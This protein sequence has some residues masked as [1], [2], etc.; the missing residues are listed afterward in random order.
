MKCQELPNDHMLLVPMK[1][2]G[3]I[4]GKEGEEI[5]YAD[6]L[7]NFSLLK[8]T[9]LGEQMQSVPLSQGKPLEEG[10]HLHWILPDSFTHGVRNAETN[11]AAYPC[12]PDRW[13]VTRMVTR[14]ENEMETFVSTK[15]FLVESNALLKNIRSENKHSSTFPI[16]QQDDLD[17]AYLGRSGEL[18]EMPEVQEYLQELTAIGYGE[19]TFCAYY[20][21]CRNV[22]GFYDALEGVEKGQITYQ[23]SGWYSNPSKDPLYG[24]QSEEEFQKK[25]K[26]LYWKVA[27]NTKESGILK[28]ENADN[29]E[30][31]MK[32]L[33]HGTI[34]GMNWEGKKAAYDTGIPKEN[35]KVAIGNSS[36]EAFAALLTSQKD[37]E[38]TDERIA[39]IF[40]GNQMESWLK[41]DGILES[42]EKLHEDTFDTLYSEE[43]WMLKRKPE[44][45][46]E[47]EVWDLSWESACALDKMNKKQKLLL[48][49]EAELLEK[50]KNLY[51]LWYKYTADKRK[52]Q[53][54]EAFKKE[55]L[56]QM[57]LEAKGIQKVLEERRALKKE[58]LQ[59][60]ETILKL[61]LYEKNT[62]KQIGTI[63]NK[64][65]LI[66]CAAERYFMP[67]EPVL[68]LAGAGMEN[69]YKKSRDMGV[70]QDGK[71]I[72]RMPGQLIRQFF[73]KIDCC[74]IEETIS[75]A[76]LDEYIAKKHLLP[77]IVKELILETM[78]LS[79]D[80]AGILAHRI[81]EKQG[82]PVMDSMFEQVKEAIIQMQ[83]GPYQALLF[84]ENVQS[85]AKELKFQGV[86][87][88]KAAFQYYVPPW[89]PLYMEWGIDYT[90]DGDSMDGEKGELNKW[91][92][93]D[94][95]YQ[96]T[97]ELGYYRKTGRYKGRM[98][99]TPHFMDRLSE[100]IKKYSDQLREQNLP[101]GKELS[102]LQMKSEDIDMMSQRLNGFHEYFLMERIS[103]QL[104]IS[105]LWL[106]D[107]EIK[108]V[109]SGFSDNQKE[110]CFENIENHVPANPY[111]DG[112]FSPIRAG[113]GVMTKL[114]LIDTF[115]RS[116]SICDE[117]N[118]EL[119][120]R[121]MACSEHFRD[122]K[123]DDKRIIF[124]PRLMQ[125]AKISA[126][127]LSA[128]D[129]EIVTNEAFCTS[130]IIGWF[131]PDYMDGSLMVLSEDGRPLGNFM[132]VVDRQRI[133]DVIWVN[134]PGDRERVTDKRHELPKEAKG[135]LLKCLKEF[136]AAMKE[137]V[138]KDS[139]VLYDFVNYLC[140]EICGMN[141]PG[142]AWKKD[143]LHF[144][145][146]PLALV[147]IGFRL[148]TCHRMS[149]P[150]TWEISPDF[151]EENSPW[152]VKFPLRLGEERKQGDGLAGFFKQGEKTYHRFYT[153]DYDR[154]KKD[155]FMVQNNQIALSCLETM[156]QNRYTLL[157]DPTLPFHVVSGILPIK[158]VQL[159][160]ELVSAALGKLN[161]E[162]PV[163]PILTESG[164]IQVP[165]MQMPERT[166]SWI[167]V[168]DGNYVEEE[169]T[170]QPSE[171][172]F[173]AAY[174]IRLAEGW[175]KL[176]G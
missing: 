89:N 8:H 21:G 159:S 164:Q 91:Q 14:E 119:Q 98:L 134:V 167:W 121:A 129:K 165:F 65:E 2:E 17:Y 4:V 155:G 166:W 28:E 7:V 51:G 61:P 25:L 24:I 158:K 95:D 6:T 156:E 139:M 106:K 118:Y 74:E 113:Y 34:C 83:K 52:E 19:P 57:K 22:F 43:K 67:A 157:M 84:G 107:K 174:P 85:W 138:K 66:T 126:S 40:F 36:G 92:L 63:Q 163:Y 1:V 128:K 48:E 141:K 152:N 58:L 3:L 9:V 122:R 173:E 136:Y 127:F 114:R 103:L 20:P 108:Q 26:E 37:E 175:L 172:A 169:L 86:F 117:S 76:F 44:D 64:Y 39:N 170:K 162:L 140:N 153:Y 99:L 100:V 30:F 96:L 50:E 16:W 69:T 125:P 151:T 82:R 62:E 68:L 15:S 78:L 94:I 31:S 116:K 124:P 72:C 71:Q 54:A 93:Q 144:N 146:R 123:R 145:A 49:L 56:N 70:T 55:C 147:Q 110:R 77:S 12:V 29:T 90:P 38:I 11:E 33:C 79:T 23:I 105:C 80:W 109:F 46:Q 45:K 47:E 42:E 150:Q 60:K 18:G 101:V 88:S 149:K 102:E 130:P 133:F 160:P 81:L 161:M 176:S 27:K 104:P 75:S 148:E 154:I 112:I 10:I 120:A 73:I 171:G 143:M 137:Q 87:P 32:T 59:L 131:V 41:Q 168:R 115:G 13:I 111:M 35:P 97:K 132:T 135:E 5:P 142:G 53:K